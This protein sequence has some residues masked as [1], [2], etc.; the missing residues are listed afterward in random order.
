[1]FT[2]EERLVARLHEEG[3]A[4]RAIAKTSGLSS[5]QVFNAL[6]NLGISKKVMNLPKEFSPWEDAV[7]LGSML[8]DGHIRYRHPGRGAPHFVLSHAEKQVE[9]LRWKVEA[10]GDLFFDLTLSPNEDTDGHRSVHATSRCHP[11]LV[12]YHD[13]FYRGR[14]KKTITDEILARVAGHDFRDA[15]LA[16]WY[17]DD[18]YRSSGNSHS[19][20][21]VLGNLE[22]EMYERVATWFS[23]L[24][25]AGTLHQ[26]MGRTT[27]RYFLMRVESAHR[28]RDAVGPYLHAS[29]Q[30]KLDIGPRRTTFRRSRR[31]QEV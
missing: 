28:F 2:A 5:G 19:V 29:M 13:S 6:A 25:Y 20:G 14:P 18:G 1:M 17:G 30:Y 15:V 24:G 10:L 27:Y 3:L 31:S 11:L 23:S 21:F 12:E 22:S 9:Y 7:L 26:H 4:P 8:G 16:V